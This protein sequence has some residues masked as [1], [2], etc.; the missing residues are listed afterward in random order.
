MGKS[1]AQL[2]AFGA[3]AYPR[4][5]LGEASPEQVDRTGMTGEDNAKQ[6]L[7]LA[8]GRLE[9]ALS[10]LAARRHASEDDLER[11]RSEKDALSD[12]LASARAENDTLRQQ[13]ADLQGSYATL[14]E[15][16]DA[17]SHRLD[18]AIEELRKLMAD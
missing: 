13:L 2:T 8:I 6:R 14:E 3:S 10:N 15:T 5:N 18:A 1:A 11:M 17:V 7:E 9:A 4:A 12:E 16:T